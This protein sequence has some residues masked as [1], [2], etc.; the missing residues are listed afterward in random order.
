MA[1]DQFDLLAWLLCFGRSSC[2]KLWY[3]FRKC[4][5][6]LNTPRDVLEMKKSFPFLP[7]SPRGEGFCHTCAWM[8]MMQLLHVHAYLTFKTQK[9]PLIKCRKYLNL[10]SFSNSSSYLDFDTRFRFFNH[11][12]NYVI[13]AVAQYTV[14]DGA[15]I[16]G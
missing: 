5:K 11:R 4:C 2:E 16:R 8:G 14:R 13:V 15:W 7:P 3:S 1:W 10:S 6:G 9:Y 12:Q